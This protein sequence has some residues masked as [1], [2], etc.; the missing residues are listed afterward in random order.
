MFKDELV[1]LLAQHIQ[2]VKFLTLLRTWMMAFT[3]TDSLYAIGNYTHPLH[4]IDHTCHRQKNPIYAIQWH[5]RDEL[6][7]FSGKEGI[8]VDGYIFL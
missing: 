5:K 3:I 8:G 6:Y 1:D 7:F 2:F 4:A